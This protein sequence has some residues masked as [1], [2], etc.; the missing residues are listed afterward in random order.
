VA[1]VHREY[2]DVALACFGIPA[3]YEVVSGDRKL[4]GMSQVRRSGGVLF[5]SAVHVDVSPCSVASALPLTTS[6]RK[7]LA[8][9]LTR[10]A[11]SLADA[12]PQ[13][14]TPFDV[15]RAFRSSLLA[16]NGIKLRDGRWPQGPTVEE[17]L[18]PQP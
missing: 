9:H 1:A 5:S 2:A 3:P 11:G 12:S 7:R 17:I 14:V 16:L 4:V 13:P 6:R 15:R 8:H 10:Y 18:D